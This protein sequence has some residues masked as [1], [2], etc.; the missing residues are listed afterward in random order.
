MELA[1]LCLSIDSEMREGNVRFGQDSPRARKGSRRVHVLGAEKAT[2]E[3]RAEQPHPKLAFVNNDAYSS[4]SDY[5]NSPGFR[6]APE[7]SVS[8][9]FAKNR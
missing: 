3:R 2:G 7:S 1:R 6:R 8:M 9:A 4:H 5:A